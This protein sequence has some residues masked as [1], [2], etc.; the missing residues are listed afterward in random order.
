MAECQLSREVIDCI[1]L[2]DKYCRF[3]SVFPKNFYFVYHQIK[4]LKVAINHV[5]DNI[6]C[7]K[8]FTALVWNKYH[9]VNWY[10]NKLLYYLILDL[11]WIIYFQQSDHFNSKQNCNY[12][13]Q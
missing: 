3:Y 6:R 1:F 7:L 4:A 9:F 10:L 11:R 2:T 13:L 12:I 8:V 5:V